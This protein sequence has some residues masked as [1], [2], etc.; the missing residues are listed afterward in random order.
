MGSG[1]KRDSALVELKCGEG[2]CTIILRRD[3][4]LVVLLEDV[5]TS[6]TARFRRCSGLTVCRIVVIAEESLKEAKRM[7]VG[8][9][10][11]GGV[12]LS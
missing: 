12:L 9:G 11:I 6:Q 4:S 5:T 2:K 7:Q 1:G 8:G 10:W 3:V